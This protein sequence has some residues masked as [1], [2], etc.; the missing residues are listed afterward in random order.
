MQIINFYPKNR[1]ASEASRYIQFF[2][3][4]LYK[5]KINRGSS[6]SQY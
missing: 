1:R 2:T 4:H 5:I 6:D 3:L